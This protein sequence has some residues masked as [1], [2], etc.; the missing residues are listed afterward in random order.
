VLIQ[1]N[2]KTGRSY[3]F[4][5]PD[6]QRSMATFLGV[7]KEVGLGELSS[8][9]L[10]NLGMVLVEGYLFDS[11]SFKASVIDLAKKIKDSDALFILSTSDI[12]VVKRHIDIFKELFS[13]NLVDVLF[14]NN[15][16][17][18]SL[19]GVNDIDKSVTLLKEQLDHIIV[20]CGENGCLLYVAEE[21]LEVPTQAIE[22]PED[23]TGAGDS[24]MGSFL[25]GL[26]QGLSPTKAAQL[27]NKVAGYVISQIGARPS[28]QI[29]KLL[30]EF[31]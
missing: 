22:I 3:V 10:A 31:Q 7:S 2:S 19:T 5:T 8:L 30:E 20:T 25:A 26:I 4:I 23:T 18:F 13:K 6:G 14:A 16:E 17:V 27:A 24:F 12:F 15:E 28:A 11:P 1:I 21:N 9:N 29:K